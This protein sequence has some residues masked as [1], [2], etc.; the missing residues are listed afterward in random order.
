MHEIRTKVFN[1]YNHFK[2]VKSRHQSTRNYS[3]A[4]EI[5]NFIKSQIIFELITRIFGVILHNP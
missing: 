2:F 3:I 1:Y 4:N 5:S